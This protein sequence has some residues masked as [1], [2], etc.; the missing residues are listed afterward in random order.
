MERV[1]GK[2]T[3]CTRLLHEGIRRLVLAD[4]DPERSNFKVPSSKFQVP[5]S[6]FQVQAKVHFVERS[7]K[8][9]IDLAQDQGAC[10]PGT[11]E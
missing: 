7:V 5:S 9:I 11:Q 1:Y 2:Q 8:V 10:A 6:K 4:V 3:P